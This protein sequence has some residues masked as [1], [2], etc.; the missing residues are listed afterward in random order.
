MKESRVREPTV[1]ADKDDQLYYEFR[2][3]EVN[4]E[5]SNISLTEFY[6]QKPLVGEQ[7][8]LVI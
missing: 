3:I 2:G 7:L 5:P 4:E 1:Q 6:K 8:K